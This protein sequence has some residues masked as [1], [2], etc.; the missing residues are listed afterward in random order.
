M[1]TINIGASFDIEGKWHI[2]YEVPDENTEGLERFVMCTSD[3]SKLSDP[4]RIRTLKIEDLIRVDIM[5]A[6]SYLAIVR[7][8]KRCF[9][10]P[11][12]RLISS[13]EHEYGMYAK[14]EGK[15][16]NL[17]NLQVVII[18]VFSLPDMIPVSR[19][20]VT[21]SVMSDP[22]AS[23]KSHRSKATNKGTPLQRFL[24]GQKTF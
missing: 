20:D 9:A 11:T 3:I 8:N 1:C 14:I 7:D 13:W 19:Y 21:E 17:S 23:V 15:A 22:P 18:S 2:S 10:I 4:S 6:D 16:I 12:L 5:K 24:A